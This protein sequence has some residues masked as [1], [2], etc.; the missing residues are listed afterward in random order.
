MTEANRSFSGQAA[1][2]SGDPFRFAWALTTA[3][4]ESAIGMLGLAISW[5]MSLVMTAGG[6]EEG[7]PGRCGCRRGP[8]CRRWGAP[9]RRMEETSAKVQGMV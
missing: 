1:G 5:T 3:V 8:H 9:C 7:D 4:T 6:R 2:H